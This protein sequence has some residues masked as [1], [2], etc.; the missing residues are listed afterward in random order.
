MFSGIVDELG[1]VVRNTI[2]TQGCLELA[3]PGIAVDLR[4]GDSIAVNGCCLTVAAPTPDGFTADVMP[5]TARRTNLGNLADRDP[6]NIEAAMRYGERV[7]GHL[8]TGHVDAI[9]EVTEVRSEGNALWVTVLTPSL[10]ARLLVERGCVAVDGMSLTVVTADDD[11]FTVSLIPHTV[12]TTTAG[13]WCAGSRV[14]LE[15]DML[16]RQIDR[17]V[18][19]HLACPGAGD[20]LGSPV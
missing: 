18:R 5:E 8:V 6:V 1:T 3:A 20:A 13:G 12:A 11:R 16:A 19:V 9:G 4:V 10:V 2:L 15:A 14:N 17:S 7:G